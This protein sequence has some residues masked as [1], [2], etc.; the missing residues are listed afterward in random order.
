MASFAVVPEKGFALLGQGRCLISLGR[1]GYD[2][3]LQEAREI[4]A[5]L[6]ARPLIAAVDDL[7]AGAIART[8]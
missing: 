3:P 2:A 4:F 6:R 7:L 8:S 5:R 1:P